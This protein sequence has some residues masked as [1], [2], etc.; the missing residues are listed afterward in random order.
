MISI[1]DLPPELEEQWRE[2]ADTEPTIDERQLRRNLLARIPDRRP[3]RSRAWCWWPRRHRFW[4]CSSG[5]KIP[6]GRG[7]QTVVSRA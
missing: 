1:T 5:S 2:W 6:A 4:R 7:N 3:P